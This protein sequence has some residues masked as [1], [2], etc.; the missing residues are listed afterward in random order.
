MS[1]ELEITPDHTHEKPAT[2]ASELDITPRA[3]EASEVVEPAI[4]GNPFALDHWEHEGDKARAGVAT[5]A[6]GASTALELGGY[7]L[8]VDVGEE[9]QIIADIE[10]NRG[11]A[12]KPVVE[13]IEENVGDKFREAGRN[14]QAASELRSGGSESP[15][16]PSAPSKEGAGTSNPPLEVGRATGRGQETPSVKNES[17]SAGTAGTATAGLSRES[18]TAKDLNRLLA[19]LGVGNKRYECRDCGGENIATPDTEADRARPAKQQAAFDPSFFAR[20]SAQT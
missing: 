5:G 8:N 9:T 12:A 3:P 1:H 14:I 2:L 16:S 15:A 10:E 4:G 7:A 20:K 18:F 19:S 11:M 13:K 17:P 6:A